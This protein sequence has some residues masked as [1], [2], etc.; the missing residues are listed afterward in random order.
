V[1]QYFIIRVFEWG[2]RA[3]WIAFVVL[4]LV[5]AVVYAWRLQSGHWRDA[6]ALNRVMAEA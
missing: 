6:E 5:I 3:S 2:P 1:A 4:I